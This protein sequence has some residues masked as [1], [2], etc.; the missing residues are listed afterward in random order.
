[1]RWLTLTLLL[2]CLFAAG[3]AA[4][5]P[6]ASPPAQALARAWFMEDT[7]TGAVLDTHNAGTRMPI[8]SI[9]KLM[10]VLVALDHHKLSDVVTVDPRVTTVGQESIYLR[11]GEQMTVRDLIKGAL[12]QSANDAADALALSV[13]PSFPAFAV[14]M[15]EKAKQL[16]LTS[17][18][19]VRPD[20]LDAPGEYSTASD[21]A[22]LAID[23]M[24]IPIIRDTVRDKTAT[25]S[26]DRTLHTWNDLLGVLP[27]VFG[28]KTGHTNDAGWCQ[29]AALQ[30]QGGVTIYAVILGSP[31][32]AQRDSDLEAMLEWGLDQY[33]VVDAISDVRV[34]AHV[35]LPYGKT[36]LALVAQ[37]SL[38]TAARIGLPLQER[39][40][41]PRKVSL[42]VTAGEVLGHVSVYAGTRLVGERPLVA[43]RSVAQPGVAR[44][45]GFYAQRAAHNVMR[46]LQ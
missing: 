22:Q 7:A 27:G 2:L 4:A 34:Y 24:K 35:V 30:G 14:L 36:P 39:V 25:I 21:V 19:F 16:G 33:R 28:V 6:E 26:G 45:V 37:D 29:V 31:S 8:A 41:A 15:N 40:V 23:A 12:I 18:H 20:G 43:A 46:A 42:P 13:A 5:K 32:E 44:R 3:S 1:M 17:S 38:L 10:T 11:A 9:T